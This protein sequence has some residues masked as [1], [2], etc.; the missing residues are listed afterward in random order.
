MK[1][2]MLL[3]THRF[4]QVALNYA[5]EFSKKTGATIG[6]VFVEKLSA[7]DKEGYFFPNDINSTDVD[8]TMATTSE[9]TLLKERNEV[10]LITDQCNFNNVAVTFKY[11]REN[12]EEVLVTQSAF[13]DIIICNTGLD[14]DLFNREH[15]L[16][17]VHCP[18]LMVPV[19]GT[20]LFT[21]VVFA[22]GG[23]LA[24]MIAIKS[25]TVLMPWCR[26]LSVTIISILTL[27][28]NTVSYQPAC[29]EWLSAHY[30]N[31]EWIVLKG[32]ASEEITAFMVERPRSLLVLGAFGRGSMSRFFND[33]VAVGIVKNTDAPIFISHA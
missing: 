23:N 30:A 25:M 19:M 24:D 9:E 1:K 3:I 18:V 14:A 29:S 6:A 31:V 28:E 20:G 17:G 12:V 32:D 7:T 13:A 8:Y 33:S 21:S 5:I 2:I 16:A 22:F 26:E 10:K 4:P 11:V 15:F 27:N